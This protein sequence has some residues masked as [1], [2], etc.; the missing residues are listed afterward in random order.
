MVR[1]KILFLGIVLGALMMFPSSGV[2]QAR[3]DVRVALPPPYRFAA[4]PAMVVIPG[5][6]V[7][8]IPDVNMDVLFFSGYWYRPYEGRWFRAR[9]YN[10]PWAFCPDPQVPAP[11]LSLPLDFREVP[12]GWRRIPYADFRRNWSAWERDRYWDKDRDWHE[13]WHGRAEEHRDEGHGRF[14]GRPEPERERGAREEGHD[15][16]FGHDEHERRE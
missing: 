3:A 1:R 15:H 9:S 12:P 7:Y 5:T 11:L 2:P 16:G 14:E 10:G 6:Y 8:T 13:G 4:P